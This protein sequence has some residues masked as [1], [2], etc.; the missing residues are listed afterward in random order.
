M[1]GSDG[2]PPPGSL[3][4]GGAPAAALLAAMESAPAAIYCLSAAADRAVWARQDSAR[5][6]SRNIR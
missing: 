3:P 2:G 6:V 4:E 1:S 5:A